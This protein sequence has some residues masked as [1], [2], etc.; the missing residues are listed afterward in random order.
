MPDPLIILA[1]ATVVV[2]TGAVDRV[3]AIAGC[4]IEAIGAR[5]AVASTV[6]SAG[7]R[8][9]NDFKRVLDFVGLEGSEFGAV[10]RF[11]FHLYQIEIS[12]FPQFVSSLRL[13]V[14]VVFPNSYVRFQKGRDGISCTDS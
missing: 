1:T 4:S 6:G 9:A 14:H 11:K 10:Q 3:R 13:R 2:D 12:W 8:T 5:C 7:R